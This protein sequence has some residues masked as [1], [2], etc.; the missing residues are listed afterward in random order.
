MWDRPPACPATNHAKIKSVHFPDNLTGITDPDQLLQ[1]TL[2]HFQ[3]ETGTIHLLGADGLLHLR[4]SAGSLPPPVME[5]IRVI[6]VGKGIAGQAVALARP[7]SICNIQ[8][9]SGDIARPGA[10]QTGVQSSLCVPLMVD[11]KPV[12]ALGIG[13]AQQR[14]FTP[15]ETKLLLEAARTI[16]Q[17]LWNS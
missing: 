15:E 6:P 2:Q 14:D 1:A 13:T 12:G 5:A 8:T 4:A 16:G 17:T 10:R 9:D 3:T 7:V 11:E